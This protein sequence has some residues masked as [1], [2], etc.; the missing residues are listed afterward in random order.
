MVMLQ[1]TGK[2]K[3]RKRM[4]TENDKQSTDQQ[5]ADRKPHNTGLVMGMVLG[6]GIGAAMENVGAGLAIG[7]ALGAGL[8]AAR[9]KK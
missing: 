9:N 3:E 2:N 1:R 4:P 6:I 5:E 7:L 8:D